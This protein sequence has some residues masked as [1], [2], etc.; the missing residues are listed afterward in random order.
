MRVPESLQPRLSSVPIF[1]ALPVVWGSKIC[2]Y[3]KFTEIPV[4]VSSR[5][6]VGAWPKINPSPGGTAALGLEP[7]GKPAV[8]MVCGGPRSWQS[9]R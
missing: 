8:P 7:E 3:Y 4:Q 2:E 9:V 1:G 6:R 5:A